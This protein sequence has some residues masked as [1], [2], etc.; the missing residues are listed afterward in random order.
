MRGLGNFIW[1]RSK[2]K[3]NRVGWK[4]GVLFVKLFSSQSP[5]MMNLEKFE[6]VNTIILFTPFSN[7]FPSAAPSLRRKPPIWVVFFIP[8]QPHQQPN[9][10]KNTNKNKT[11]KRKDNSHSLHIA[12]EKLL[13]T[14]TLSTT[15]SS[16]SSLE[17]PLTFPSPSSFPPHYH[18]RR[19]ATLSA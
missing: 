4:K 5:S 17:Y 2:E 7:P 15:D 18:Y 3:N 14:S 9:T 6:V 13:A 19:Q 11:K 10:P 1:R 12:G 16:S 8:T